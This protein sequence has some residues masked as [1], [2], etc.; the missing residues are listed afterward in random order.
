MTVT[1]EKRLMDET[2][3]ERTLKRMTYEILDRN[4]CPKNL[5]LIGLRTRGVHLANRIASIIKSSEKVHVPVG[6]LDVTMYRDDFRTALKQPEVKITTIPFDI[7]GITVVIVDDVFYTG[8]TVRSALD[9][10]MDFGRPAR[11]RLAVLIDRGHREL[12][13]VA[14][15]FGKKI[16]TAVNEEIRVRLKEE[17]GSDE[18]TLVKLEKEGKH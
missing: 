8:R 15:F 7:E 16:K 3:I 9:A 13:L 12:P 2:D 17:D 1:D 14:D 5:A 11:V 6:A 4:H 10:L 18:V